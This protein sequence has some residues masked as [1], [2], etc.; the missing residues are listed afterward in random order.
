MQ[1]KFKTDEFFWTCVWF[2]PQILLKQ[3]S[4]HNR[5]RRQRRECAREYNFH[6]YNIN[7]VKY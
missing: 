3:R 4:S 7:I 2:L 5:L 1:F 6:L